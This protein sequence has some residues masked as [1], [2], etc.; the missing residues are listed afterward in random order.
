MKRNDPSPSTM[1]MIFFILASAAIGASFGLLIT[2]GLEEGLLG[3]VLGALVGLVAGVVIVLVADRL[4]DKGAEKEEST[5]AKPAEPPATPPP[6]PPY[7]LATKLT[8]ADAYTKDTIPVQIALFI[9]YEDPVMPGRLTASEPAPAIGVPT[10]AGSTATTAEDAVKSLV[11]TA[12]R[13]LILTRS[14]EDLQTPTLFD[15]LAQAIVDEVNPLLA[16][17]PLEVSVVNIEQIKLPDDIVAGQVTQ[18]LAE[19]NAE[20][21]RQTEIAGLATYHKVM[22]ALK[23]ISEQEC[24]RADHAGLG[25]KQKARHVLWALL[26]EMKAQAGDDEPWPPSL[27]ELLASLED[28]HLPIAASVKDIAGYIA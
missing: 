14:I 1:E 27:D 12:A 24:E 2:T 23:Q 25:K 19:W 7:P 9:S 16:R 4:R 3:F 6:S 22:Q 17:W 20:T 10:T 28:A 8:I 21:Q 26:T 11:T 13:R 18:L 15:E 5:A